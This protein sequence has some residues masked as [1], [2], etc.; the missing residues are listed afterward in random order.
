MNRTGTEMKTVGL[1]MTVVMVISWTSAA[2]AAP[3]IEFVGGLSFDFGDV[4]SGVT[5]ERLF[6]FTNTGDQVLRIEQV[7]GG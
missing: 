6:T 7:K 4:R 2:N 5:V 3:D 1:L